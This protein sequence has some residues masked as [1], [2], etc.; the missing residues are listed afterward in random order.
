LIRSKNPRRCQA[1][2]PLKLLSEFAGPALSAPRSPNLYL[3]R[4]AKYGSSGG[5]K[6]KAILCASSDKMFGRIN[7]APKPHSHE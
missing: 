6:P 7:R 4:V 5:E 3:K 2:N 1:E